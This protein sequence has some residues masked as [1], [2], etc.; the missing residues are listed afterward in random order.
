MR[1]ETRPVYQDAEAAL[2]MA[3]QPLTIAALQQAMAR[4]GRQVTRD[5]LA[6]ALIMAL[7]QGRPTRLRRLPGRPVRYGLQGWPSDAPGP[8]DG[9][10]GSAAAGTAPRSTP[11]GA[12]P[13]VGLTDRLTTLE[14]QVDALRSRLNAW[15]A[16]RV[17][18]PPP[19]APIPKGGE[20]ISY[21][22][23]PM[24]IQAVRAAAA[25]Q[26]KTTGRTIPPSRLVAA[27]LRAYLAASTEEPEP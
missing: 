13:M 16:R 5:H 20:K 21:R 8:A 9:V 23:D 7:K 4:R 3:G 22:L 14:A 19:P 24:L 11:A 25:R 1:D 27:A 6:A 17:V 15:E 2:A 18:P 26:S 12:G 10:G